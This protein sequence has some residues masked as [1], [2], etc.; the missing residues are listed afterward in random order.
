MPTPADAVSIAAPHHAESLLRTLRRC[1]QNEAEILFQQAAK[2]D[3][4]GDLENAGIL[5]QIA[6]HVIFSARARIPEV[7]EA[8]KARDYAYM[9]LHDEWRLAMDE[10]CRL[11]DD[12]N[13]ENA[14]GL[15]V[16]EPDTA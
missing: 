16:V 14:P 8:I 10:V 11:R 7:A 1:L 6:Q 2:A 13:G 15:E 4:R 3:D 12:R 9:A 5:R